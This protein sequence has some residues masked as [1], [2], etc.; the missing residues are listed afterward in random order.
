MRGNSHVRF[1][2]RGMETYQKQFRQRAMPRPTL[3]STTEGGEG[4][5]TA[6]VPVGEQRSQGGTV[7]AT[8]LTN[9]LQPGDEFLVV[10]LN[11]RQIPES[12][13]KG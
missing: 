8:Y 1:G 4:A 9:N 2:G 11:A 6:G 12:D 10:I 13:Y 3:A 5:S 7:T